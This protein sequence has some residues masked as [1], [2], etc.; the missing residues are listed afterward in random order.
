MVDA[1][2]T[3]KAITIS[4]AAIPAA[5][6]V[7]GVKD[8]RFQP[9]SS[10]SISL[11]SQVTGWP[12]RANSVS[13][14]PNRASIIIAAAI[15]PVNPIRFP[16]WASGSVLYSKIGRSWLAAEARRKGKRA[17]IAATRRCGYPRGGATRPSHGDE[18]AEGRQD[19][20]GSRSWP[21]EIGKC[22]TGEATEHR[23]EHKACQRHGHDK[24]MRQ[25]RRHTGLDVLKLRR[26]DQMRQ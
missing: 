16:A 24:L 1:I 6:R 13:G 14:H 19:P 4:A 18:P 25:R 3:V 10:N 21:I 9:L 20:R 8:A 17:V 2:A 11:P 7:A 26:A 22:D 5:R 12:K 15:A 23:P